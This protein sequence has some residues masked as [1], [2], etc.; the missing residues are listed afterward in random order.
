M[1]PIK[2]VALNKECYPKVGRLGDAGIDLRAN[3]RTAFGYTM[4][5][6]KQKFL[7]GT[8]LR[9][10]IPVGWV[11]IVLPR[12]GRAFSE[13]MEI[14]LINTAG[15]IDS[16]YTGEIKLYIKN[17]SENEFLEIQDF[18]RL[19]QMVIV[20]HYKVFDNLDI[21]IGDDLGIET[22]RGEEGFGSSGK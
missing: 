13:H 12:S 9:M 2:V 7:V 3:I 14:S 8:G 5:A 6:P 21:S 10:K 17:N 11:G 19:V 15:V 4:I 16:N 1:E 22:S 20:P 18:E